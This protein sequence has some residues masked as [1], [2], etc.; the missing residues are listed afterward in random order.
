MQTTDVWR[1]PAR[2][3]TARGTQPLADGPNRPS[4][5]KSLTEI[6]ANG[7]FL[8]QRSGGAKAPDN[9]AP[10]L[11]TLANSK[12][13]QE[14]A[15][16]FSECTGLPLAL[17]P[18]D[19]WKLAYHRHSKENPF[20]G[21][22]AQKSRS[23]ALCLQVQ[24]Q[25]S[26]EATTRP[27]TV[28]CPAGLAETAV[29]VIVDGKVVGLL[30]TGQVF[31]RRPD[32]EQFDRVAK[33]AAAAALPVNLEELRQVYQA[34]RT[35]SAD[36]HEAAIK[37]LSVFAQHLAILGHQVL[38]R[39]ENSEPPIITRAKAYIKE[40]HAENLSLGEVAKAVHTSSFYFCKLFRRATGLHFTE[41]V[42]RV[43]IEE[44]K[45]LLL[46][47]N[48]QVSEI[49]F[50]VGFQSLTHFN[51]VFKSIAGQAPT[52]YRARFRGRASCPP[53]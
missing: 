32:P 36:R 53:E 39:Q 8:A 13:Y 44:A 17:R 29:P 15:R 5:S 11:E 34:T 6:E 37:M 26:E 24:Q 46:N 23:C 9:S 49:A 19:S 40:R 48:L 22:M 21:I 4:R 10:I 28:L 43:R 42:C 25:L 47:P 50:D 35:L 27:K 33:L 14:Y 45:N 12:T 1:S 16:A 41:Y 30:Q 38:A 20:C 31:T 2:A 3:N 52:Q 51:R 18:L 7:Q